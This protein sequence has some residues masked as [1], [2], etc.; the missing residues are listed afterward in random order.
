M[1]DEDA[2]ERAKRRHSWPVRTFRL[3]EEPPESLLES[4]TAEER[5]AMMWPL[6]EEAWRLAGR[7]EPVRT[8]SELPV[9]CVRR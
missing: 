1:R 6:A 8:R 2:A 4:T 9:R 7:L 5:I 3:G